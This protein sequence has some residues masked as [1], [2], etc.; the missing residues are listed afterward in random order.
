[1]YS[2]RVCSKVIDR[3]KSTRHSEPGGAM[4]DALLVVGVF[5]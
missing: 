2:N 5:T 4:P 1:M 3:Q